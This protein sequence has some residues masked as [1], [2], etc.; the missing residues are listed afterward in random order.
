MEVEH[1]LKL[2][3]AKLQTREFQRK[4]PS[5]VQYRISL[6][7]DATHRGVNL[8]KT[9]IPADAVVWIP[10]LSHDIHKVVENCHGSLYQHMQAWLI[11]REQNTNAGALRVQA[12]KDELIRGFMHMKETEEITKNVKT[13]K[14]TYRAIVAA[15]GGYPHKKQDMQ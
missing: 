14:R 10:P 5:G 13:L 9:G 4:L 15:E 2:L 8:S 1:M 7:G 12:C 3:W 6:D 11:E